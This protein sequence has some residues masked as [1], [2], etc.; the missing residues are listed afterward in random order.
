MAVT[1]IRGGAKLEHVTPAEMRQFFEEQANIEQARD[2]ERF[3]GIKDLRRVSNCPGA[4]A[5][6]RV[7]INDGI[8]PD[9]GYKWLVVAISVFLAA[10]GT[11]EAL[12]TSDTSSTLGALT[13]CRPAAVFP[14]SFQYQI[15]YP[16]KAAVV[17]SEGEG[18]YLN[19]SQNISGYMLAGWITPAEMIGRFA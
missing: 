18:L 3:K 14:T 6:T 1:E 5:G 16:P 10:A 2:R 9:A 15:A 19:F 7:T 17:L 13:Q 4:A 11:G 8:T 12:I